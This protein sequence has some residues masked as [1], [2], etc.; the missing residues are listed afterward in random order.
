VIVK[1]HAG[2]WLATFAIGVLAGCGSTDRD[3]FSYETPQDGVPVATFVRDFERATG[4]PVTTAEDL[5]ED[6]RRIR[7]VAR[8]TMQRSEVLEFF[9]T[10]LAVHVSDL[11]PDRD[12]SFVLEPRGGTGRDQQP[13]RF[14]FIRATDLETLA[15]DSE[16]PIVTAVLLRHSK[17]RDIRA[18]FSAIAR[19]HPVEHSSEAETLNAIIFVA[20][21]ANA[22]AIRDA[23]A[24]VDG[25]SRP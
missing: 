14:P 5:S 23:I 2:L 8:V 18:M 3:A 11:I 17:L 13:R 6:R 4:H 15:G 22:L 19:H 7:L 20:K 9:Q 21:P 1:S 16:A 12:E 10:V 25:A 24:G